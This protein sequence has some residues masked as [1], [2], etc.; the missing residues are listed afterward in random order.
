MESYWKLELPF[1]GLEN[2][3]LQKKHV[4]SCATNSRYFKKI[5][6]IQLTI[7]PYWCLMNNAGIVVLKKHVVY[8]GK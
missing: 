6:T 5:I 1:V 8:S 2:V 7:T 3:T 4:F